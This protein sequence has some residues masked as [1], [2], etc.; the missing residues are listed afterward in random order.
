MAL[1][2]KM[3]EGIRYPIFISPALKD[4]RFVLSGGWHAVESS[5]VWSGASSSLTLPVPK[6]CETGKCSAILKFGVFGASARRPVP[7]KFTGTGREAKWS[8]TLRADGDG[9]YEVS[10]PLPAGA[11]SRQISIEVPNATSPLALSGSPDDRI[12]GVSLRQIDLVT[13]AE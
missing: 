9:G 3:I 11:P 13:A 12:L 5:H 10:V 1:A 7:V 4:V 6:D 8:H 2:G